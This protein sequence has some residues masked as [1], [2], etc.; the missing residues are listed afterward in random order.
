MLVAP[1]DWYLAVPGVT[2]T[3]P[4]NQHFVRDIELIFLLL[5]G[6]FLLGASQPVMRPLMDR[7]DGL[8]VRPRAVHF[9]EVAVGICTPRTCCR[10]ISGR[11]PAGAR[12][13]R[14]NR[15]GL[16]SAARHRSGLS[17]RVPFPPSHRSLHH[18]IV[19]ISGSGLLG[20]KLVTILRGKGRG[21]VAASPSSGVNTLTGEG[22]PRRSAAPTSLSTS[23]TRPPSRTP[24]SLTSSRRRDATLLAAEVAAGV[25][26]HVALSVVGSE[27]LPTADTSAQDRAGEAHQGVARALH[28]R[29][30]RSS[31]SSSVPSRSRTTR[32]TASTCR[33]RRCTAHRRQRRFRRGGGCGDRLPTA[34]SR[35]A[36]PRRSVRQ[37]GA[38]VHRGAPRRTPRDHRCQGAVF[39]RR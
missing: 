14:L 6:A 10:A 15:L 17:A 3:G 9:W 38:P 24:P 39:R 19:V 7:R 11:D 18:E 26:H 29:A 4:F 22:S 36:A 2:D 16:S 30:R 8:A 32:P 27:R 33:R 28:D 5:G 31:T 1:E 23:P 20:S 37:V 13:N 21:V 12:R 34:Q 25:K 35:S